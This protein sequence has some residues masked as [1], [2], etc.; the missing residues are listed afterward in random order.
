MFHQFAGYLPGSHGVQRRL[1]ALPRAADGR[2]GPGRPVLLCGLT[3]RVPW[4]GLDLLGPAPRSGGEAA[5]VA[6]ERG[7]LLL[8]AGHLGG[9]EEEHG[10]GDPG[11][12]RRS[13]D[14]RRRRVRS[15]AVRLGRE[16]RPGPRCGDLRV[17]LRRPRRLGL[18]RGAG[19]D[20]QASGGLIWTAVAT[21]VFLVT[22]PWQMPGFSTANQL[23]L[24]LLHIA[25]AAVLIP[26]LPRA[27]RL[28]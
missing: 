23:T 7:R 11:L 1:R 17:A 2:A 19:E 3:A 24:A 5:S 26:A 22:L 8:A 15:Q 18:A 4:Q 14:P 12:G 9:G 25:V 27:A 6:L 16:D 20:H 28:D 13:A 10:G 21:I